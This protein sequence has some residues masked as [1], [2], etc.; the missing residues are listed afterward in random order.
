MPQV[1]VLGTAVVEAL[2]T[3]CLDAMHRPAASHGERDGKPWKGPGWR[4]T[5]V[6]MGPA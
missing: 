6:S 3:Q 2:D 1:S 4:S 5:S